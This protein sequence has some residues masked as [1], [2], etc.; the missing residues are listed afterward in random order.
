M[1]AVPSWYLVVLGQYKAVLVGFVGIVYCWKICRYLLGDLIVTSHML[2]VTI[3]SPHYLQGGQFVDAVQVSGCQEGTAQIFCHQSPT[4]SQV[5]QRF[6]ILVRTI[7]LI[8][9]LSQF[10]NYFPHRDTL[11]TGI[12]R[13]LPHRYFLVVALCKIF[14]YLNLENNKKQLKFCG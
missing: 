3:K 12:V 13:V 4:T 1:Q 14:S 10:T 8:C 7:Y 11:A 5:P 9:L 2:D 6:I